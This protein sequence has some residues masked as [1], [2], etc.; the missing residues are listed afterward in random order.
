VGGQQVSS[1]LSREQLL[2]LEALPKT[3]PSINTD[4]GRRSFPV[5]NSISKLLFMPDHGSTDDQ[6]VVP[7]LIKFMT[8]GHYSRRMVL[9]SNNKHLGVSEGRLKKP[10]TKLTSIE[11]LVLL[12]DSLA[13]EIPELV[14]TIL[15]SIAGAMECS[16][17]LNGQ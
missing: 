6:N 13:A 14:S 11:L 16:R 15:D 9:L 4:N 17:S 3:L 2:H 10:G 5:F 7:E 12:V 1:R 8:K